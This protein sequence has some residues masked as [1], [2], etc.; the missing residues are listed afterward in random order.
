VK[1]VEKVGEDGGDEGDGG[2]YG[3]GGGSWRWREGG[4]E[5]MMVD[6]SSGLGEAV[7]RQ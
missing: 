6:G 1:R 3:E 5:G 7:E 2:I 4:R